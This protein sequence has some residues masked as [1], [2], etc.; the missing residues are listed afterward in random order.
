[1]T[2]TILITGA[3]GDIADGMIRILK[4]HYP[5][6]RLVGADAAG[7]WPAR[8]H[9]DDVRTLPYASSENY[10]DALRDLVS[11]IG[12]DLV[13]PTNEHELRALAHNWSAVCDIAL[14]CNPP[15]TT[16]RFL[17]KLETMRW[18]DGIGVPVPQTV[19]LAEARAD[20]LPLV[21]KPRFSSGS[22]NVMSVD[23]ERELARR[24]ADADDALVAQELLLPDDQEFTCAIVSTADGPRHLTMR[25]KLLGG[26]TSWLQVEPDPDLDSVLD[27]IAGQ[28][29]D[30]VALNVQLRRTADG[31]RIF[32]INPRFSSTVMMRHRIGFCDFAHA[33]DVR[34]GLPPVDVRQPSPGQQVYRRFSEVVVT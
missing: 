15:E 23:D 2:A 4:E 11:E 1:M 8:A 17:D 13:V 16:L 18:L 21:I 26:L 5:D 25:R 20:N 7:V 31:P 34:L 12:A 24:Q 3:N 22:R 10:I 19:P 29:G 6:G 14:L 33:C 30:F 27:A 32:E 9:I 28:A